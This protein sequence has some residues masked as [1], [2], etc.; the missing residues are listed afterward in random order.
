MQC[1]FCIFRYA[2][3]LMGGDLYWIRNYVSRDP[4]TGAPVV[5]LPALAE[6]KE[7]RGLLAMVWEAGYDRG[8]TDGIDDSSVE[9]QSRNPYRG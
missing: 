5:N 4:Y 7:L 9:S 6:S 2:N 3:V 1:V 8:F